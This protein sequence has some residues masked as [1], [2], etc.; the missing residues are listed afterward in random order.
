M[1]SNWHERA[2]KIDQRPDF[3]KNKVSMA[4][5]CPD[6]KEEK[7]VLKVFQN[8]LKN[9]SAGVPYSPFESVSAESKVHAMCQWYGCPSMFVTITV[10]DA[11]N[12]LSLHMCFP[13]NSNHVNSQF[14]CP[15]MDASDF[16]CALA[17][18]NKVFKDNIPIQMPI[19][20]FQ[21][22]QITCDY[23]FWFWGA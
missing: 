4:V 10:N 12:S 21:P 3:C 19:L 15:A 23:R 16:L 11:H 22:Y 9:S 7:E 2:W 6:E 18:D 14:P 1:Q 17:Q 5:A 20:R 13:I 8:V